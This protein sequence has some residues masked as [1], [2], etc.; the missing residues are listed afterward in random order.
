M[1]FYFLHFLH[2]FLIPVFFLL[3]FPLS[4]AIHSYIHNFLMHALDSYQ[5]MWFW[6]MVP[7]LDHL[8]W[9]QRSGN[10]RMCPRQRLTNA[11]LSIC[12]EFLFLFCMSLRHLR[13]M[14]FL[15]QAWMWTS[16]CQDWK[17]ILRCLCR[18]EKMQSTTTTAA[19]AG[20]LVVWNVLL[21]S[22]GQKFE[23]RLGWS[24]GA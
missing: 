3:L 7:W 20:V 9:S 19:G 23:P 21:W 17:S 14:G 18:R 10:C 4:D 1:G 12:K 11:R 6:T 15:F 13:Y 2:C 22:R 24:W 8:R 16:F 5:T